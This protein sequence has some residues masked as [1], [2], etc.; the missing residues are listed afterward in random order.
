MP[1]ITAVLTDG[2][3]VNLSNERHDWLA[4][5]PTAAGGA[6]T[7]PTPY[8]MLLGSL[9]SCTCITIASYCKHKGL[10]LKS[11]STSYDFKRVHADDCDNCDDDASGMIDHV[12]SNVHIEG[13]FDDAQRKRISDIATRC[14][15][16]KTLTNGIHIDDVATFGGQ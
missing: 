10:N 9:A 6:D 1:R 12:T 15:V 8:E 7:G 14:P 2:Y 13:D 16:H 4:D 11:V 3:T 5:E